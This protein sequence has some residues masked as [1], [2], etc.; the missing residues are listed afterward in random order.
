MR[1]I[2]STNKMFKLAEKDFKALMN[3]TDESLFDIEIFGFHAHQ[4][5]EKLLKSWLNAIGVKN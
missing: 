2:V 3:M 1:T 5:V 4:T